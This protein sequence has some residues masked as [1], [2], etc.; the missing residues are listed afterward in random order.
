VNDDRT[1]SAVLDA[2]SVNLQATITQSIYLAAIALHLDAPVNTP[3]RKSVQKA[4]KLLAEFE[5]ENVRDNR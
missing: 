3:F 1:R 4:K 5:K 2:A